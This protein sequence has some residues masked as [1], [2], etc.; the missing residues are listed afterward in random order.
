MAFIWV[1]FNPFF[2]NVPF[3]FQG[4]QKCDIGLKR[5]KLHILSESWDI[6]KGAYPYNCCVWKTCEEVICVI[7]FTSNLYQKN[8]LFL[9]IHTDKVAKLIIFVD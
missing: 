8:W 7:T 9:L 1:K 2:P 5:A 4:V 6:R 3:L